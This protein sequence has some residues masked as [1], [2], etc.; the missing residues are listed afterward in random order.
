MNIRILKNVQ[1][2]ESVSLI[3]DVVVEKK[4]PSKRFA[5][6][7]T[8]KYYIYDIKRK[9]KKEEI[10]PKIKKIDFIECINAQWDSSYVYFTA[11]T[12]AGYQHKTYVEVYR[13]SIVNHKYDVVYTFV[14]NL[15]EYEHN[16]KMKIFIL[17]AS[18]LI[19]QTAYPV[20]TASN[21]EEY[22]R[23]ELT[24]FG[25]RDGTT[26]K[27]V[28]ENLQHNGID[29]IIPISES[30]SALKTGFS[31][32]DNNRYKR[33][34]KEESSVEGI[35]IINVQQLISDL[36]LN[37]SNITFD[38]ISQAFYS[39][40]FPYMKVIDN[41]LIYSSR[42]F[43]EKNEEIFFY[44]FLTK[45]TITCVNHNV[46]DFGDMAIPC[47]LDNSPFICKKNHKGTDLLNLNKE[48]VHFS[49]SNEVVIEDIKNNFLITSGIS[50][51]RFF[52]NYIPN[53]SVYKYPQMNLVLQENAF[54]LGCVSPD[55]DNL[56][57]FIK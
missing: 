19:I 18:Y 10:L 20:K 28:D 33:L 45:E 30:R 51:R 40:T 31:L 49:F 57:I 47:I 48:K 12:S 43:E 37:S 9:Y 56:D 4:F 5:S 41:Y 29:N 39:K 6:I 24:L 54:Y 34:T 3:K 27:I 17:N 11:C 38:F 21:H 26:V 53:F 2:F 8:V 15:S 55:A 46:F 16:K 50:K 23:Y 14:D 32:L 36:L 44:N 35:S 13:Y 1:D 7:K 22:L 42:N 25:T 52:K